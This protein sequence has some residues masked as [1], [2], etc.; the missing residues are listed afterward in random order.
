[1]LSIDVAIGFLAAREGGFKAELEKKAAASMIECGNHGEHRH[2]G[3][4]S[5][6]QLRTLDGQ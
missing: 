1:M 3:K 6:E 4:G 2:C 5:S